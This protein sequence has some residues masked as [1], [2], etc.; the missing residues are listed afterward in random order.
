MKAQYWHDTEE[1]TTIIHKAIE[2]LDK[3]GIAAI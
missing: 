3:V 1:T 2:H